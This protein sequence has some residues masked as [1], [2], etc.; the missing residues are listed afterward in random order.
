MAASAAQRY[1]PLLVP[2]QRPFF[3]SVGH[4]D[5]SCIKAEKI[6]SSPGDSMQILRSLSLSLSLSQEPQ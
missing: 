1:S 5:V 6:L 2:V 3:N 4:T